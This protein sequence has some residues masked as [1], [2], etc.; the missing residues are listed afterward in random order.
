[1]TLHRIERVNI[2]MKI[3]HTSDWHLGIQAG[4]KS[5]I[6]DQRFFID[7]IC[8]IIREKNID[9]VIIAGDIFDR[10][11][12]S[13]EAVSLYNEAMTKM[14]I[15]CDTD[16]IAVAGNHDSA[17]RIE[18]CSE[19]LSKAG[20]YVTGSLKKD[21]Y[22][23]KQNNS[24]IVSYDDT[25]IYLLPW[26][27]E[28]KVRSIFPD[29]AD[30]I[31]SLDDAY[32]VVCSKLKE[33]FDPSKNHIAVSHSYVADSETSKSDRA[34]VIG[35]ADQISSDVFSDFDYVALGH[36][37]KPQD[38]ACNAR[39]S[40]TP[41]P[42]SFGA[43]EEQEKSVTV[44][45]TGSMDREIIPIGQLHIRKT[46]TGT[47]DEIRNGDFPEEIRNGYVKIQVT[48]AYVGLETASEIGVV[49]PEYIE[50][51]GKAFED[52]NSE[53]RMTME[54][55]RKIESDPV[56]IFRNYCRDMNNEEPDERTLELF[57]NCMARKEGDL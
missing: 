7:K 37:H 22:K 33:T 24:C 41:L 39:Y 4:E 8:Q 48:D 27:K 28:Q 9:L 1:M 13:A 14:C 6:D 42:Y 44:I 29:Q 52:E 2:Q 16:V 25:D 20:L 40:G 46:V 45:D 43:E 30:K 18:N 51:S 47:L 54:E 56:M 10:S 23:K 21:F 31:K 26:F 36:I 12:P 34:A 53:I 38:A 32:R 55:F 17:E 5:M 19:L 3:L 35:T 11:V 49:F 50:I 15:E 57:K